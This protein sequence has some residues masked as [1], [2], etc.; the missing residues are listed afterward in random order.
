MSGGTGNFYP[1]L[2]EDIVNDWKYTEKDWK[3]FI[4][5][6]G[7]INYT[8]RRIRNRKQGNTSTSLPGVYDTAVI[9]EQVVSIG[10]LIKGLE[11]LIQHLS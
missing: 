4:P 1:G 3:D 8:I 7:A 5:F 9:T 6:A 11:K 2:G 10:F